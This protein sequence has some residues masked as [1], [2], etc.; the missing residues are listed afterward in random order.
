MMAPKSIHFALLSLTLLLL[1][2]VMASG[3][4]HRIEVVNE[5]APADIVG[6]KMGSLLSPTGL[7]IVRGSSRTV[8]E[9]WLC[10][11][12]EVN[13]LEASTPFLYPFR[14]GQLIGVARYTRD[15]SDFRDQEVEKG[16]YTLRY[17]QMPVDGAHVGVFPTRDFLLLVAI[18]DEESIEDVEYD[19]LTMLSSDA[20][21]SSHPG[22][23]CLQKVTG[24]GKKGPSIRHD[25]E[26]DWWI[27]R[28]Q[29]T[30]R[31]GDKSKEL[32]FD[33]VVVGFSEE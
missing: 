2:P 27:A 11:Q 23:L 31:A 32:P 10:K 29:G 4:D 28:L 20:I 6:P 24:D 12:W 22:L 8:C 14:V 18:D 5:P 9:I 30:A 16:V 26:H 17:A 7:K 19:D 13:S 3:A 33:L 1:L 21:G 15:G 25:E